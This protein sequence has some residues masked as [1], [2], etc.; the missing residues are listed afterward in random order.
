MVGNGRRR[1]KAL[2]GGV[3]SI[4]LLTGLHNFLSAVSLPAI[5]GLITQLLPTHKR[6]L[7]VTMHSL[8]F[9]V[10]FLFGSLGTIGFARYGSMVLML[11]GLDTDN[12]RDFLSD[13]GFNALF[14]RHL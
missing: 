11:Y 1:G 12:L 13:I 14:K 9:M 4:G 6:S 3:I 7:G 2:G 5:M 10:A 8:N